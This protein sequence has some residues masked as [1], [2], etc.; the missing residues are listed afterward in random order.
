MMRRVHDFLK[1]LVDPHIEEILKWNGI[2]LR[3]I[4]SI[5]DQARERG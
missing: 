2:T 4:S 3:A 5:R 1:I